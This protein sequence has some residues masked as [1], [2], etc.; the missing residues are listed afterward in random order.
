MRIE[1][2][3]AVRIDPS[4]IAAGVDATS[5]LEEGLYIAF[6]SIVE[7]EDEDEDFPPGHVSSIFIELTQPVPDGLCEGCAER[8][9]QERVA[10]MASVDPEIR[11]RALGIAP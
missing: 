9:A 1:P 5:D 7:E 3:G 11:R 8:L 6:A 2:I 10:R 4:V